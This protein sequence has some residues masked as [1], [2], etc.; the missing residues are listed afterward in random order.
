MR[1]LII[2]DEPTVAGLVAEALAHQG[3]QT[4]G[5]VGGQ[6]GAG[7]LF[8]DPPGSVFLDI[9]MPGLSGVGAL[10]EIRR[11]VPGL[12]VVVLSGQ[13]NSQEP[14]R[15]TQARSHRHRP[16]ALGG[17]PGSARRSGPWAGTRARAHRPESTASR[18]RAGRSSAKLSRACG[19]GRLGVPSRPGCRRHEARTAAVEKGHAG[20]AVVT[21]RR[22]GQ[23]PPAGGRI[24]RP[25]PSSWARRMRSFA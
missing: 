23:L 5:G 4:H 15:G 1:I 10:R 25:P 16:E 3:H 14:R 24:R 2:E 8:A 12:P 20:T 17:A 13:A 21:A 22:R 19:R 11:R 18:G 9:V 7:G 6:G